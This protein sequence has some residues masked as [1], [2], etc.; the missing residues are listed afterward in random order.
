MG[1]AA[2]PPELAPLTT[3]APPAW[4]LVSAP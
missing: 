2:R 1:A 4:F 3:A